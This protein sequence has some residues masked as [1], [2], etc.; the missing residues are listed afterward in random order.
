MNQTRL[1]I[2]AEPVEPNG[3]RVQGGRASSDGVM[4]AHIG[5]N[6]EVFPQVLQMHVPKGAVIADVTYGKGVFWQ[7]VDLDDYTVLVSDL[8][9]GVDATA[10]PYGDNSLDAL[11]LDPPYMEG[12]FRKDVSHMAGGGTH[13]AFRENYSNG[14]ATAADAPKWHEAVLDLYFRAGAEAKRVLRTG[15]VFIVKCQDEVSAN[16]QRL[17]HVELINH[18]EQHDFYCK[19]LFVVVRRN[20]P[21]VSRVKRQVHARKNHSYFLVFTLCRAGKAPSAKSAAP[22]LPS[23]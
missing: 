8:Q 10:L 16:R 2:A 13:A 4:S 14:Q 12:L 7:Q 23:R 17:T 9:G 11:V 5:G 18:F 20:K 15:G 21:G 1:A 6:A 3:R 19:D 22:K